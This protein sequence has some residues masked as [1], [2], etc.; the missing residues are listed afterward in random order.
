MGV[1]NPPMK[2]VALWVLSLIAAAF[3]A[4]YFGWGT[5][6]WTLRGLAA[7]LLVMAVIWARLLRRR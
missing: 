4:F 5:S 2:F 6:F 7:G 3:V 1:D